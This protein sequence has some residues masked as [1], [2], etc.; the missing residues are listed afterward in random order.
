MA[1]DVVERA[2]ELGEG[3]FDADAVLGWLAELVRAL[4]TGSSA[5]C[6]AAGAFVA[7]NVA[8]TVE[9]HPLTRAPV[10]GYSRRSLAFEASPALSALI[11]RD[12]V[13]QDL[14]EPLEAESPVATA[15]GRALLI[16][17]VL[18]R[19]AAIG[20]FGVWSIGQKPTMERFIRFRPNP[21]INRML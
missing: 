13:T 19:R 16:E 20:N 10:P 21:A 11:G 15:F 6:G 14:L 5:T 2:V 4:R 7:A 1:G 18:N 9:I 12:Q 3:A 17:L 8:G